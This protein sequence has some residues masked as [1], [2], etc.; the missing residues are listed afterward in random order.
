MSPRSA[1]IACISL[2]LLAGGCG[3]DDDSGGG[4]TR[5]EFIAE[6]DGLCEDANAELSKLREEQ[7]QL[8]PQNNPEDLDKLASLFEQAKE[9]SDP[10]VD[11][12]ADVEP[13]PEMRAAYGRLLSAYEQQ[14]ALI[15]RTSDALKQRDA[16]ALQQLGSK[17]NT[18]QAKARGLA[19][20]LGFK[21]CGTGG[22]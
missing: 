12:M 8:D 4:P 5:D 19:H 13:P 16:A 17:M 20:G 15:G 22:Q 18:T 3:G 2:A 6:V 21:V 11:K 7:Q 14:V 9:Q 10:V 1:V